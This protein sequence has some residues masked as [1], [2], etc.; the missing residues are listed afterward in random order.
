MTSR[1]SDFVLINPM[2]DVQA[3]LEGFGQIWKPGETLV[4]LEVVIGQ[5]EKSSNCN[6]VL[7]DPKGL[8]AAALIAHTIASGGIK[9][10]AGGN[11]VNSAVTS[12]TS[13]PDAEKVISGDGGS[14]VE[15]VGEPFSPQIK[16]FLDLISVREVGGYHNHQINRNWYFT[17][18]NGVIFTEA[19]A[20]KEPPYHKLTWTKAAGRYQIIPKTWRYIKSRNPGKFNDFLPTSQ[21]RAAYWLM[22]QRRMVD[23]IM[24]GDI[25]EAIRRGR[26]EWTSLPG[27]AEQQAGWNLDKALAYYNQRLKYY[28]GNT[29]SVVQSPKAQPN[30]TS[31]PTTLRPD[32]PEPATTPIKGNKITID[33]GSQSFE[34]YHQGTEWSDSG[35]TTVTGQGVRWVLNRRKRNKTL[36]DLSLKQLAQSIA[37]AHSMKLDWQASYDP[38][39]SHI[40]QSGISD[41]QLLVR[42]AN[43]AGLWVS[44]VPGTLTV[45]SR[46]KIADTG[47]YVV[48]GYNLVRYKFNDKALGKNQEE[49]PMLQEEVKV[50]VEPLTGQMKQQNI[51]VD[52]VKDKSASGDSKPAIAGT[53]KPG[54]DALLAQNRAKMKRLKGL[55]SQFVITQDA[56]SLALKPMDTTRT[57]NFPE[58]LNRIWFIDKVTHKLAD[59]VTILD[60]YSP[61]EVID[62]VPSGIPATQT[63][64]ASTVPVT[65]TSGWV[66]PCGGI[67]GSQYGWRIHPIH[68]NR[69]FHYGID[70][71]GNNGTPIVSVKEGVCTFSG[72]QGGYGESVEIQH[73]DGLC[74]FY[75][76]MRSGSRTVRVGSQVTKGQKV[77]LVGS[78]GGSTGP[79]LH[80]EIRRSR[81]SRGIDPKTIFTKMGTRG[82]NITAGAPVG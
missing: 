20:A 34:F 70:V 58:S 55:P 82:V 4:D 61:I 65:A 39:Y 10:L 11:N 14:G 50:T 3:S 75:A 19:E 37:T 9:D 6:I 23:P 68:G 38:Q 74:S 15:S 18:I 76:H 32:I 12:P 62:S 48:K 1:A 44:E 77:G 35:K 30:K 73:P 51:D 36:K 2:R 79:H 25:K 80:F 13:A 81:G 67:V 29:A 46:D 22:K 64:S 71:S 63:T 8:I 26:N 52:P 43:F 49:S 31:E 24:A 54:Q 59:A 28:Q 27:A 33:W 17:G 21:D 40:D 5:Q 56:T 42:E 41:Y 60:V 45:K 72:F 66:Y 7:S 53:P 16:A 69:R 78:T 47:F 57:K